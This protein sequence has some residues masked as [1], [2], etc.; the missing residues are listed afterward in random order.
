MADLP[1]KSDFARIAEIAILQTNPGI[2]R[3]AIET[4]GTDVHAFVQAAAAVG[5][6][7]VGQLIRSMSA[8]YVESAQGEELD[9][10]ILD[11]IGLP[12]KTAASA[13]AS[14]QWSTS[15]AAIADFL[16]LKGTRVGTQDGIEWEVVADTTFPKGSVGPITTSVRSLLAG[17][18][19]YARAGTITVKLDQIP[20]APDDLTCTNLVASSVGEDEEDESSYKAAYYSFFPAARRGV[21]DAITARA[22]RVPGVQ[23]AAATEVLD[24]MGRAAHVV[25][26]GITDRFT[27]QLIK[28][29]SVP[30]AYEAQSQVLAQTVFNALSDTRGGGIPVIVQVAKTVILP[31]RL[32]L[33]F[34]AGANI[35]RVAYDARVAL[36]NYTNT[37]ARG[38]T[39]SRAVAKKL[40]CSVRGLS[41]TG[42]E[43]VSPL[44][45]VVARPLQA[46]RT[47]LSYVSANS[48]HIDRPL[49]TS[50]SA[51]SLV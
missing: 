39:W 40:L 9:G 4:P 27:E 43:I 2:T 24:A 32:H 12:R 29:D 31:I 13:L 37:L 8:A 26:L 51:D 38:D 28:L 6:A 36:V 3:K 22:L 35:D 7:V 16:I 50:T 5:D 14:V 18:N 48:S 19:I 17:R 23:T 25:L 45:D 1:T 21:L 10:R 20:N 11:L 47:G 44:G 41:I 42:E 46:I 33:S 30:P 34:L 15:A 49:L